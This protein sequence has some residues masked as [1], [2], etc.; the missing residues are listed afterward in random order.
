MSKLIMLRIIIELE[1][2][3]QEVLFGPAASE[4]TRPFPKFSRKVSLWRIFFSRAASTRTRR[5]GAADP[6]ARHVPYLALVER[7]RPS[8]T[9]D[10][11]RPCAMVFG[12]KK[13]A[14]QRLEA[15]ISVAQ[16]SVQQ[17]GNDAFMRPGTLTDKRSPEARHNEAVKHAIILVAMN[18][19]VSQ[20]S[21]PPPLFEKI[22]FPAF[23]MWV[24]FCT[25]VYLGQC[26]GTEN[27]LNPR[28]VKPAEAME[29]VSKMQNVAII[30][31]L[32]NGNEPT[33]KQPAPLILP[34]G[35]QPLGFELLVARPASRDFYSIMAEQGSGWSTC[36][37][38]ARSTQ[39]G[40]R[41]HL[42]RHRG[43]LRGEA[44][45]AGRARRWGCGFW[46]AAASAPDGGRWRG[47][48]RGQTQIG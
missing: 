21:I 2:I 15:L 41:P 33:T 37:R 46:S 9:L 32:A 17:A 12:E 30:G 26:K 35:M 14:C 39:A 36:V 20:L 45:G 27:S 4:T 10:N 44:G 7:D 47:N 13:L 23:D 38:S 22:N 48:G 24:C 1:G 34:A 6:L 28:E 40:S 8:L 11:L 43:A 5:G 19:T 42:W 29:W 18:D 31:K 16:S 25:A 3:L